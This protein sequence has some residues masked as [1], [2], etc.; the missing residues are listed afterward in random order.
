MTDKWRD[1]AEKVCKFLEVHADPNVFVGK[2]TSCEKISEALSRAYQQGGK[3]LDVLMSD[4][5]AYM[6]GFRKG[7]E[8]SRNIVVKSIIPEDEDDYEYGVDFSEGNN[9]CKDIAEKIK[10][11]V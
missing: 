7:V 9:R 3:D 5:D 4:Q 2:C 8:E 6:R 1:E 11:L 10:G